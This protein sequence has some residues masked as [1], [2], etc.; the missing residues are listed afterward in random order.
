MSWSL[1]ELKALF[2]PQAEQAA[3]RPGLASTCLF[4]SCICHSRDAVNA[5]LVESQHCAE[6][7][8]L[9]SFC[10]PKAI[11]LCTPEATSLCLQ[12]KHER[13]KLRGMVEL[14]KKTIS[15]EMLFQM[16]RRQVRTRTPTLSLLPDGCESSWGNAV[17][18]QATSLA[19]GVVRLRSHSQNQCLPSCLLCRRW[20]PAVPLT[21]AAAGYIAPPAS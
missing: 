19:W 21:A 2:C 8:S 15:K 14:F 11:D 20:A 7:S 1:C 6:A 16:Q 10:G 13:D 12:L 18:A 9:T 4:P 3:A 5:E 17:Q